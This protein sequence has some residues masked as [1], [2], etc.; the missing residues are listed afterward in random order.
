ML[1][2]TAGVL[3]TTC[4]QP[5][6]LV[7]T[8]M[9]L[10]FGE[11][12]AVICSGEGTAKKQYKS[13]LDALVKITKSEGFF[14]LYR[15]WGLNDCLM[16]SYTSGVLRQITYT[17]TRLGVFTNCMN[18]CR[19]RN[20]GNNISFTQKLICGMIGGACGAVVGNP[21]E[22]T[23]IRTS[24]DNRLPPEQ[25]RGY[26]NCFQAIYRICKEEGVK[27]L[28]KGTSA[29]VIR[30]MVLNPA[31]LGG[32][33]QAKELYYEKWHLF[34]TDG[35]GLYIASSLTSGLFCSF[36]SLPVDIIKTRLQMMK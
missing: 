7:K 24:A 15:G 17:T 4:V 6:D 20:N 25:R 3:A 2:G 10:R 22:V 19:K 34:K 5:M 13:S 9:Q 27:T 8:R 28:W 14:K 30:A 32:Y 21:A 36:V 18:Y 29:T 16:I 23:L 26:T 1:G 11:W 31:Q 35:L 12:I 33:A